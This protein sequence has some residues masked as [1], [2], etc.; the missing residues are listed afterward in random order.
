[1]DGIAVFDLD[2]TL[3]AGDSLIPFLLHYGA[4]EKRIAALSR[5]PLS[6]AGVALRVLPADRTKEQLCRAFFVDQ[7]LATIRARAREFCDDWLHRHLN[8]A[9]LKR[10]TQHR[11][12]GHRII[13][14]TAG[15]DM[16]VESLA[17]G[18]GITEV[19]CTKL[20]VEGDRCRGGFDGR[21]CKG[22]AKL[23]RLTGYLGCSTAPRHSFAYGDSRSDLPVL[24]W[25]E[26]GFL[27]QGRQFVPVT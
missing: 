13:L 16:L 1:M 14:L 11:Q 19:V 8:P 22:S 7:A 20:R 9:G 10:L 2:G 26:H 17:E 23:E 18:L 27:R 4:K 15:P 12:A 5:L 25:V 3:L 6:L 21:N 24:R